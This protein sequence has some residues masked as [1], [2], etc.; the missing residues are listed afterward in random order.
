MGDIADWLV[1]QMLEED[2]FLAEQRAV[3]PKTIPLIKDAHMI[4]RPPKYPKGDQNLS[5]EDRV[6][7]TKVVTFKV[8]K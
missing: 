6:A 3:C 2:W 7:A 8:N 1:D 5:D 4:G